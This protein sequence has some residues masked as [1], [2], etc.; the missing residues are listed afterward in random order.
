MIYHLLFFY[1]YFNL[2]IFGSK[3]FLFFLFL[4]PRD[5]TWAPIFQLWVQHL[6]CVVL[7]VSFMYSLTNFAISLVFWALPLLFNNFS[8][9]LLC[10]LSIIGHSSIKCFL[11]HNTYISSSLVPL[12]FAAIFV[13]LVL[14]LNIVLASFQ[15]SSPIYFSFFYISLIFI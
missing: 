14:I 2:S 15:L 5:I 9:L 7:Y 4:L 8:N 3:I 1:I 11:L 6:M 12:K 13:I 10:F